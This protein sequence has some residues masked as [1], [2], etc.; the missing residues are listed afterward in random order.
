VAAHLVLVV[1]AATGGFSMRRH[2]L[3]PPVFVEVIASLA[4]PAASPPPRQTLKQPVVI[5][6]DPP[7]PAPKP[8]AKARPK[9]EPKPEVKPV[10]EKKRASADQLLAQMR[11][12]VASREGEAT[13]QAA[14]SAGP[15]GRVDPLLALYRRK[16]IALLDANFSGARAFASTPDLRARYEVR[17]DAG[18]GV[19][20]V[21]LVTASGNRFFDEAAERAIRKSPFPP[22]P[23][24]D[25]TLDV[26]FQPGTVF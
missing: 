13:A 8:K 24:G 1:M 10:P 23:R 15:R 7:K 18:G 14:A 2:D 21:T 25:L 22:P 19:R 3:P 11:K 9:P 20:G 12:N 16:L 6:K 26:T 4:P 5:P 17:I